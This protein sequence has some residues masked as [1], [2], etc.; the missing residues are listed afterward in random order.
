MSMLFG[1]MRVGLRLGEYDL[2]SEAD[3]SLNNVTVRCPGSTTDY[4]PAQLL[5][6]SEF[7]PQDRMEFRNDIALVR[8]QTR[9]QFSGTLSIFL[10]LWVGG[11]HVCRNCCKTLVIMATIAY[12][13]PLSYLSFC[14]TDYV[15]TVC[16]P[17][18]GRQST[19]NGALVGL[20]LTVAGWGMTENSTCL[21]LPQGEE[22]F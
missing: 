11:D 1:L 19:K 4:A 9:A 16:L 5:I 6:H 8:L 22:S 3:C 20:N 18:P 14:V 7:N 15:K 2:T 17:V 21:S 12:V 10:V 13:S